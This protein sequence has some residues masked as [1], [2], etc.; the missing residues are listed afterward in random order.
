MLV[1]NFELNFSFF[2]IFFLIPLLLPGAIQHVIVCLILKYPLMC[3]PVLLEMCCRMMQAIQQTGLAFLMQAPVVP[4][5]ATP[6]ATGAAQHP[7]WIH[8]A[9]LVSMV[10]DQPDLLRDRRHRIT[11]L[12]PRH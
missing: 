9:P 7:R 10:M 2:L 1:R 5:C 4:L 12:H 11:R 6:M 3:H 8:L